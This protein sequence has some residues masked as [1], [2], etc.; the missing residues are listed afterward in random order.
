MRRRYSPTLPGLCFCRG[1]LKETGAVTAASFLPEGCR[2]TADRAE[3]SCSAFIQSWEMWS[4]H[5]G[6]QYGLEQILRLY[7][8]LMRLFVALLPA[9]DSLREKSSTSWS[10]PADKY[11]GAEYLQS[12]PRG[13]TTIWRRKPGRLSQWFLLNPCFRL[14]SERYSWVFLEYLLHLNCPF[15]PFSLLLF[16]LLC[17]A[18]ILYTE[19]LC[20]FIFFAALWNTLQHRF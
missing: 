8:L 1:R 19:L 17:T 2:W 13:S 5:S 3:L 20:C 4:D 7:Q 10:G 14:A 9:V 6:S 15:I 16:T 18:L 12:E 11:R